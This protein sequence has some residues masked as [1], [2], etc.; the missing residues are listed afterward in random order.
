MTAY[1]DGGCLPRHNVHNTKFHDT[2]ASWVVNFQ[3]L[4]SNLYD[5]FS[6]KNIFWNKVDK[7][8]ASFILK[9][10]V[11]AS[12]HQHVKNTGK[13]DYWWVGKYIW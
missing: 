8:N 3:A 10:T 11:Q 9:Q 7:E 4:L 5:F 13:N 2:F 1:L 12:Y 6:S